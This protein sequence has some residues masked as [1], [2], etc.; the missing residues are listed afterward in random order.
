MATKLKSRR[1]SATAMDWMTAYAIACNEE[2]AAGGR[3]VTA[4]TNGAA[5]VIPAVLR[6]SMETS[7][8]WSESDTVEFLSGK[9]QREFNTLMSNN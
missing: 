1:N 6:Y 3:V 4:P 9:K 5:G 7:D 2:N 8:D